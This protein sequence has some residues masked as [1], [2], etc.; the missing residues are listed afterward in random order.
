MAERTSARHVGLKLAPRYRAG[1]KLPLNPRAL[2]DAVFRRVDPVQVA[3]DLL[4][5]SDKRIKAK[6]LELLLAYKFGRPAHRV[7]ASGPGGGP[8]RVVWDIPR[9]ARERQDTE[10]KGRS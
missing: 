5:G 10:V 4:K 1:K 9:P 2:S 8:V 7:E 3:V 6:I